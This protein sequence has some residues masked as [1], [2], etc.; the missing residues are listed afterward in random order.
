MVLSV[1]KPN[2]I[3]A[4]IGFYFNF[5]RGSLIA[6]MTSKFIHSIMDEE[7]IELYGAIKKVQLPEGNAAVPFKRGTTGGVAEDENVSKLAAGTSGSQNGPT[8][9][10]AVPLC[11]LASQVH[12]GGS[13]GEPSYIK[14][15]LAEMIG[16]W[17]ERYV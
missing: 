7:D 9:Q 14:M 13:G 5:T 16:E 15:K 11:E 2:F 10:P 1:S 12:R 4:D 3:V 8:V 17:F 6:A